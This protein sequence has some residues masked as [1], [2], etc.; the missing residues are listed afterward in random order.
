MLSP[1][2]MRRET[3]T[4]MTVR[5]QARSACALR[6]VA[7]KPQEH[8]DIPVSATAV[9]LSGKYVAFGGDS[10]L[11]QMVSVPDGK[12]VARYVLPPSTRVTCLQWSSDGRYLAA[13]GYSREEGKGLVRVWDG[14]TRQE[15]S[16]YWGHPQPVNALAWSPDNHR[17]ASPSDDATVQIWRAATGKRVFT[18]RGHTRRVN[19]LSWTA[20][21]DGKSLIASGSDDRMV[22]VWNAETG[23]LSFTHAHEQAVTAVT[24][25]PSGAWIASGSRDGVIDYYC[26]V[27][28]HLFLPGL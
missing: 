27:E 2:W 14:Q 8:T 28:N 22:H 20:T 3:A 5:C 10:G 15:V 19:T 9:L 4:V 25:D 18:Y 24:W 6:A 11:V 26:G 23:Q 21:T 16:T 17:I 1:L 7:W 13:G 12:L